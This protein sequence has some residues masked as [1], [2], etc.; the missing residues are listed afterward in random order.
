MDWTEEV[1]KKEI[2][3]LFEFLD[4]RESTFIGKDLEHEMNWSP[5]EARR[6][7]SELRDRGFI[8]FAGDH[9]FRIYKFVGWR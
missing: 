3:G 5:S 1:I 8:D 2:P 4:E 7:I 6:A 9:R